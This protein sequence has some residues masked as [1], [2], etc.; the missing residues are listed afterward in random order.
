MRIHHL[1]NVILWV[2]L[3]FLIGWSKFTVYWDQ[4]LFPLET[5]GLV[6]MAVGTE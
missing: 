2:D 4:F 1:F 3:R 5:K 6:Y